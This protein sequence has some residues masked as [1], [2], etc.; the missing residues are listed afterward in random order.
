MP[1]WLMSRQSVSKPT[2][3]VHHYPME[4]LATVAEWDDG[5]VTVHESTLRACFA[6]QGR[7]A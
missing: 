2:M 4:L 7:T 6:A 3:S 5:T 1:R